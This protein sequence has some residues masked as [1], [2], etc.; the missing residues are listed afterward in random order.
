MV[1]YKALNTYTEKQ[2][3]NEY[4]SFGYTTYYFREIQ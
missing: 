2:R 1:S 3:S 4:S